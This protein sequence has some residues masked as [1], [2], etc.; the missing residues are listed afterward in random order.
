[1]MGLASR[2]RPKLTDKSTDEAFTK[3]ADC[4][5]PQESRRQ[6][7]AARQFSAC[8]VSAAAGPGNVADWPAGGHGTRQKKRAARLADGSRAFDACAWGGLDDATVRAIGRQVARLIEEPDA[9]PLFQNLAQ[10]F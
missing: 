6:R 4:P 9:L 7:F 2:K 3:S 1:M 8:N 10:V 5:R